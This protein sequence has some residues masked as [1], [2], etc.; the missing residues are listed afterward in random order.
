MALEEQ[1]RSVGVDPKDYSTFIE[2]LQKSPHISALELLDTPNKHNGRA[3][4]HITIEVY[5]IYSGTGRDSTVIRDEIYFEA[6]GPHLIPEYEA[7]GN[8][9]FSYAVGKSTVLLLLERKPKT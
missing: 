9:R 3:N 2:Q 8:P 6:N 4:K 7:G 1:L 5:G